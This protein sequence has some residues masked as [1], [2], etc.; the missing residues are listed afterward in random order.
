VRRLAAAGRVTMI[1]PYLGA[2]DTAGETAL[3]FLAGPHGLAFSHDGAPDRLA[4]A[5]ATHLA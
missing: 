2:V 4:E 5:I 3:L 1:Q